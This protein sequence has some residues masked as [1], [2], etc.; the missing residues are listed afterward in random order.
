MI[1]KVLSCEEHFSEKEQ[2]EKGKKQN[3]CFKSPIKE[4]PGSRMELN[5]VF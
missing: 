3:L 1:T 2:V 4:A 5:P